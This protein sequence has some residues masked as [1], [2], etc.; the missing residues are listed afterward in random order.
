MRNETVLRFEIDERLRER[1]DIASNM[2]LKNIDA[3]IMV[4]A[5]AETPKRRRSESSR[6]ARDDW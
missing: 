1:A 2:Q 5:F 3:A 6:R 4:R